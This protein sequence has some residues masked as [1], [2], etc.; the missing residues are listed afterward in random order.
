MLIKSKESINIL[1]KALIKLLPC[2]PKSSHPDNQDYRKNVLFETSGCEL[3][4]VASDGIVLGFTKLTLSKELPKGKWL[5][6]RKIAEELK[7]ALRAGKATTIEI[8]KRGNLLF[9]VISKDGKRKQFSTFQG[10]YPDYQS[11]IPELDSPKGRAV[12]RAKEMQRVL[13][14]A[15]RQGFEIAEILLDDKQQNIVITLT[16]WGTD[17]KWSTEKDKK[18]EQSIKAEIEG[19]AC[20]KFQPMYLSK[21]ARTLGGEITFEIP[22][23]YNPVLFRR[24]EINWLTMPMR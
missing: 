5:L 4:L 21:M 6:C 9:R 19:S 15:S 12:F 17:T 3:T 11:V 20:I 14:S 23:E 18:I 22:N 16:K 13:Q 24:E 8:N 2:I 10:K 7:D 1:T